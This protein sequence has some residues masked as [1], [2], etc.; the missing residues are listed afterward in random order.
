MP[1]MV[2]TATKHGA[3]AEL[4]QLWQGWQTGYTALSTNSLQWIL[5]GATHESLVFQ[6]GD[7][8][9]T[10]EAILEVVESARTGKPLKR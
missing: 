7:A 3:S 10:V 2:L 9:V 4:E 1:L 6:S 5:P 8:S